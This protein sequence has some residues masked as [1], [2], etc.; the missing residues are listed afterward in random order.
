MPTAT[1]KRPCHEAL[2]RCGEPPYQ[3]WRSLNEIGEKCIIG[4]KRCQEKK[5]YGFLFEGELKNGMWSL[6]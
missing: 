3:R 5:A 2:C 4:S 1:L 6:V